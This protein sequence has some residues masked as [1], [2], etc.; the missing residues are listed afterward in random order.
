MF[1]ALKPVFAKLMDLIE[2]LII[3]AQSI[4][5]LKYGI[6]LGWPIDNYVGFPTQGYKC[7]PIFL[8]IALKR[9]WMW[10]EKHWFSSTLWLSTNFWFL[11]GEAS[12]TRPISLFDI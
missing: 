12:Y 3:E 1:L 10:I 2:F 7:F 4:A 5:Q 9:V 6:T 8:K 11:E